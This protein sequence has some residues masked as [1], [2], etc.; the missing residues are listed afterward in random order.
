MLFIAIAVVASVVVSAQKIRSLKIEEVADFYSAKKE[1][2]F[3]VS[4]WAT[5]CKPCI[6][7]IPYLQS[8][9]KKYSSQNV[10]LLLVSLDLPAFY[11]KKIKKFVKENNFTAKVA[12]LDETDANHFCPVIDKSW[13]GAMPA[14][15]FVNAGTGYRKFVESSITEEQFEKELRITIGKD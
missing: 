11:P 1:G 9:S 2:V 15:L 7:E 8:I 14:T 10:D 4:F 13:S 5:F 12:W 3:V 6:G